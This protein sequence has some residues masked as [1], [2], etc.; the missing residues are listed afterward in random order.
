MAPN[1]FTGTTKELQYTYANAPVVTSEARNTSYNIGVA[2]AG[3]T[4]SNVRVAD[5]RG[6]Y[7]VPPKVTFNHPSGGYAQTTTR[8]IFFYL[9]T[10]NLQ[11]T[12]LT[13]LLLL[14]ISNPKFKLSHQL[15]S[16]NLK[17]TSL[18]KSLKPT[19]QL[20]HLLPMLLRMMIS[21]V[22][23]GAGF[24]LLSLELYFLLLLFFMDS[25]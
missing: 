17:L 16:K 9:A 7:A 6:T 1:T 13:Q 22:T 10:I 5:V 19:H 14:L 18:A 8:Y 15:L 11:S 25:E 21:Y 12:Q 23:N 2:G 20:P 4:A 24:L 3:T